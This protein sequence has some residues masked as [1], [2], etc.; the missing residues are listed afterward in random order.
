VHALAGDEE[1]SAEGGDG[2]EEGVRAGG[3][4]FGQ[5]GLAVV[6]EDDDEGGPGVEIDA[7]V[8]S[9]VNRRREGT[10]DEGSQVEVRRE[11]AGVP[12]QASHK[13]AFMSIHLLQRTGHAIDGSA[14]FS[15]FPRVSRPLSMVVR[16]P[17]GGMLR[18]QPDEYRQRLDSLQAAVRRAG[19]DL[20]I[21]SAFDSIYYLTG[22]G[23]EPLERPFFLFIR[24]DQMPTLLVPKLDH[25]HMKQAHHV[26][27]DDIH[28]YWEYPAPAG[29]GWP[30]RLRD[31]IGN[32]RAV[33]VEP[34]LRL[35]VA[36]QLRGYSVRTEPLVEQLRLVK[37]STEVDMIRR[38]ARYADIGV[39]RLLAASYFGA[40]VAE[41][42][43]ETRAVTS[44]VIR[45][46]DDWEPLTT[47]VVM[48][49]WAA[50]YSGMPHSVPDL[51]DRLCA[52][53]HVALVL[54]RINGYAAESE[55]T[56]FT[57][58]PS[59]EARKAFAAMLEARQ[60]AFDLVRPGMSC[61]EL[62]GRVNEFLRKKEGYEGYGTD[63]QRLH[64]TGHGF[65][66]GNHEA[67]WLAE[68]SEDQLA[69]NMVI[70]IEPGIYLKGLGGFRHSD[71]VLV[72]H[73]GYEVLTTQHGTRLDDL[74]EDGWKPVT[75]LK[76]WLVRRALRLAHKVGRT[77]PMNS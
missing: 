13:K 28:T 17:E 61:S 69:E 29:R 45:E 74:I 6:V 25:E 39:Q 7:G 22:A 21:V 63:E 53:P 56:Y 54:T 44:R 52:G 73:K 5:D 23:F 49:T 3:Q 47:K 50:P 77:L 40:T 38:A 4:V 9:G 64:R 59:D 14:S 42:F 65:G 48:A 37:T 62:D 57:T 26:A 55:R 35:D 43:A 27:P 36:D 34:T 60:V 68:G 72:T 32:A 20:F 58:R 31:Q 11:A 46:V 51:N 8:E 19:L 71:T 75:R 10:H 76:G 66:L 30:D 1:S 41:G 2:P 70:S 33:G 67:P 15:A 18:I 24:P 16:P 12:S